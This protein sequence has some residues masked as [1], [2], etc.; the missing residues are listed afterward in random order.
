MGRYMSNEEVMDLFRKIDDMKAGEDL[1]G[2]QLK[3][4]IKKVQNKI[5]TELS[6]LVYSVTKPYR[7]FPNYEDLVQEGFIGLIKAVRR[8]DHNRFPNFFVFSEQW[9]RHSVKRAASRFDIVY[10]PD[11]TRVVY[12]E[13]SEVGKEEEQVE[14]TPEEQFFAK[15]RTICME[16]VLHDLPERDREIVRRIFGLGGR[17]P[18][19]L[20]EIGPMFNLTHERIRQIKNKA[21]SKLRKSQ[22]L[23]ELSS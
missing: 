18:Q 13:P 12:A 16:K 23:N 2:S 7:S 20:R 9:I 19:T 14:E 3:E 5:V 6:F 10:N 1:S 22:L 15:E 11:K 21:I 4:Q 17:K 8:F